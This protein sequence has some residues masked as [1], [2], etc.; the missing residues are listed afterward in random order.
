MWTHLQ[1]HTPE[2][3]ESDNEFVFPYCHYIYTLSGNNCKG[4]G[5]YLASCRMNEEVLF[6]GYMS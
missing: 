3:V 2:H 4:S 5:T 1:T 6:M